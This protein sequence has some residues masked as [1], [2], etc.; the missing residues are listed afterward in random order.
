MT[1]TQSILV[2]GGMMMLST[3]ILTRG[4]NTL[5]HLSRTFHIEAVANAYEIGQSAI[6][7]IN[8]V[9][10]D[11]K[12][13][14]TDVNKTSDLSA[15]LGP[16]GVEILLNQFDDIDDFKNYT[17]SESTEKLGVFN[18][19]VNVSYGTTANPEITTTSRTFYK[20]IEILITNQYLLQDT[21]RLQTIRGY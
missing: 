12:T 17:W 1:Q 3:L 2:I 13:V 19:K 6:E 10:F 4:S 11:E 18:A 15:I 5:N 20:K 16:D 14:T 8:S 7:Q 9:A 21:L